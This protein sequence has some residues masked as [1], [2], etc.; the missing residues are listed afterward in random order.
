MRANIPD[1]LLAIA[2]QIKESGSVPL[3]RLTVLKNG[4]TKSQN[5]FAY[6]PSL[7]PIAQQRERLQRVKLPGFIAKRARC[8]KRQQQT[9]HKFHA[10]RR[11]SRMAVSKNFQ[12]STKIAVGASARCPRSPT[13]GRHNGLHFS[14]PEGPH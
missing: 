3:T 6:S 9:I 5:D 4:L 12:T 8:G 13:N 7:S 2:H 10:K 1:K 11:Q 14:R